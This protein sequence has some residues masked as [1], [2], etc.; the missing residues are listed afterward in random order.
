MNTNKS[1]DELLKILQKEDKIENYIE[2]KQR[3][4]V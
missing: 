2:K 3:R 1:T 4:F